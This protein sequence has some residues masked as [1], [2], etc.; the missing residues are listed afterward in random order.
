MS[1]KKFQQTKQ[2]NTFKEPTVSY[3][4]QTLIDKVVIMS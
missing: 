4:Q 2:Q 3:E 1:V